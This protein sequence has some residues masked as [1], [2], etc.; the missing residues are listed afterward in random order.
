MRRTILQVK[1][2]YTGI[3]AVLSVCVLY[4]FISG[5]FN[6][7]TGWTWVALSAM[8]IVRDR[9]DPTQSRHSRTSDIGQRAKRM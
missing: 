5:V 7:I 2:A 9:Q 8:F 6:R 4:I 3:F 1:L